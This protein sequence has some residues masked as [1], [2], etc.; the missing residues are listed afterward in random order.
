MKILFEPFWGNVKTRSVYINNQYFTELRNDNGVLS[1]DTQ[2]K[3][4]NLPELFSSFTQSEDDFLSINALRVEIKIAPMP[5]TEA[6]Q[7][8]KMKDGKPLK[9]VERQLT[10]REETS[11]LDMFCMRD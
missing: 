11:I 5:H 2:H 10:K 8:I 7:L 1:T 3:S 4:V 9:V 6:Y